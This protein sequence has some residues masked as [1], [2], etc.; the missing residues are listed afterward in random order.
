MV[1]HQLVL[2]DRD[3]Q[4]R[5][6][7]AAPI[8]ALGNRYRLGQD[9]VGHVLRRLLMTVARVGRG[10]HHVL[11]GGGGQAKLAMGVLANQPAFQMRDLD[12]GVKLGQGNQPSRS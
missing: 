8:G 4:A 5:A 12:Q 3:A 7:D 9:V 1:N 2:V 10:Q 6:L 11:A